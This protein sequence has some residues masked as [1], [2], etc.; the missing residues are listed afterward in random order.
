MMF[1]TSYYSNIRRLPP[2]IARGAVAISRTV[3][4]DG[5]LL[6]FEEL[7][8][9][10]ALVKAVK[11]GQID[12]AGYVRVFERDVL[13]QLNQDK[14]AARLRELVPEGDVVLLCY[15][16]DHTQCHRSLVS[17]WLSH[18]GYPSM[19]WTP[20]VIPLQSRAP[21]VQGRAANQGRLF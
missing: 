2:E 5:R 12:W 8:P 21:K 6:R 3:P 4:G 17:Q 11:K 10:F 15:E 1:W 13:G 9:P 18:G 7:A 14:V 20:E 19:E 16:K